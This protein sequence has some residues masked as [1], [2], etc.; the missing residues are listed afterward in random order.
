VAR[1]KSSPSRLRVIPWGLLLRVGVVVGQR[2]TALSEKDRARLRS[3]A[4]DSRGRLA[5]L[6]SKERSELGKLLRK[7]DIG[8]A[9][10]E[11]V[12]LVRGGRHSR[13]RR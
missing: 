11:I 3:L 10:R 12:P 2:W 13:K 9:V 5:N 1:S 4:R 8:G 6:S 7:L